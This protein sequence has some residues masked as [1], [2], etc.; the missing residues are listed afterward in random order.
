M[1]LLVVDTN[2]RYHITNLY[3][4]N[5]IIVLDRTS[6]IPYKVLRQTL[7]EREDTK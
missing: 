4:V 1:V 3:F 6:D 5:V 2:S 7:T